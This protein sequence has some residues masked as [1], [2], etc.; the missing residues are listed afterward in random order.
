MDLA[1]NLIPRSCL[2]VNRTVWRLG[3]DI[4]GGDPVHYGIP[5]GFPL[6]GSQFHYS[7]HDSDR[8]GGKNLWEPRGQE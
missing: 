4:L 5:V 6:D 3:T 2:K 8:T 7:L 1:E